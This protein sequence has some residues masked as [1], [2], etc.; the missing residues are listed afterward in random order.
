MKKGQLTSLSKTSPHDGVVASLVK[1]GFSLQQQG[2]FREAQVFYERALA[3]QADH[4]DALQLYGALSAQTKQFS[5]TVELLTKAVEVNP[6]AA[7]VYSNLGVAFKELQRFDEAL[8]CFDS[9]IR[10]KPNFAEI[11]TN[12][13]NVLKELHRFNEALASYDK[14]ISLQPSFAQAYSN[15]GN[16]LKELQRFNAAL[17]S[18]DKAISLR[19]NYAEAYCNRGIVLNELKRIHEALESF[20]K[21]ISLKPFFA[22]AYSNR[23]NVLKEHR[24]YDE[25][26]AS[27]D[28]AISLRPNYAE[29]YCNRGNILKD[30]KHF[31]EALTSYDRSINISPDYANA[32]WNLSLCHLLGGNLKEGWREYEWRWKNGQRGMA[33]QRNFKQ[34]LWLGS[35]SLEGKTVLLHSEQGLGD[36]IQFCRYAKWVNQ[37]GADVILEVQRPLVRLLHNLEGVR[38][39]V[40]RGDALPDFDYQCP[41]LSLPLAFNTELHS[42][43][44][45]PK[46]ITCDE[47]E[48]AKWEIQLGTKAKPRVG[49]VWSSV[50]HF[51]NDQIRSITLAELLRAL[52]EEGFEY[53]CLQKEI[54]EIDQQTLRANPQI[55][56]FGDQLNDFSDTAHLIECVD[57]VI[58]TCTSVPHLS[59]ALGK[60]TWLMLSYVPDWRWFLDRDDSPWYPSAKLYRQE[61]SHDWTGVF[62]KVRLDLIAMS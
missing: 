16:V 10:L 40:A 3:I 11:H 61:Q 36:T 54:K 52:P 13:G 28:K 53:I 56:F 47:E 41:L 4:F 27:Y 17:A 50:S 1:Q 42:I 34:P 19:P 5:K 60:E 18:Y 38:Q 15:R 30:L 33:A 9:A 45:A 24:L 46:Y 26:L 49:L 7:N 37:L 12:R 44:S 59:C 25:A 31:D 29:A 43:P 20:D 14:A 58:S 23:G 51:K 48:V 57:W 2:K 39:I 8:T 21:A 22:E 6:N 55:K 62:E 32:H 35:D